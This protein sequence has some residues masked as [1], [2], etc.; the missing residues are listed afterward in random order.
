M[1]NG[2]GGPHGRKRGRPGASKKG[3]AKN[4]QTSP[5]QKGWVPTVPAKGKQG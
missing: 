4:V 2:A 1:T 3:R 5:K